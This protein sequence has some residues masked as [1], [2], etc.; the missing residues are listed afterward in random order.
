[1]ERRLA[2]ILVADA[3]DYSRL[4]GED[5]AGTYARYKAVRNEFIEPLV[6]DHRGRIVKSLGDGFLVEFHSVV[7][8]VECAVAWQQGLSAREEEVPEP[9]RLQFRIG[10]NLGDV[11]IEDEDVFGDGVNV[12]TRL[13]GLADPG[14]VCISGMV[15]QEVKSKLALGYEDLGEQKLKNIAEPLRVYRVVSGVPTVKTVL[16][17]SVVLPHPG[18]PLIAV[19]PFENLSGDPEQEY[20]ADGMTRDLVTE[21]GRFS[22]LGVIS[23]ATMF[24]YKNRRVSVADIHRDL[25]GISERGLVRSSLNDRDCPSV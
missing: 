19:L 21:V 22:T 13:E 2:A 20:F 4:M 8:A 7:D 10:I 6:A 11:I 5:E 23:A 25:W 9:R 12:A 16:S 15:Y 17:S 1:M 14:K 24:A 3:V 18:K